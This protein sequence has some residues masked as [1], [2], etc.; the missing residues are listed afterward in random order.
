MF[1]LF[2]FRLKVIC[3]IVL[4]LFFDRSLSRSEWNIKPNDFNGLTILGDRS[5]EYMNQEVV[6]EIPLLLL[7]RGFTPI[8]L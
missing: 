3:L 4:K 1:H 2:L 8:L 5:P 6:I 7:E